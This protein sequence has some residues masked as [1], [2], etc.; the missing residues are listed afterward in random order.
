[1]I[2]IPWEFPSSA[3]CHSLADPGIA[4]LPVNPGSITG[5]PAGKYLNISRS[6][7]RRAHRNSN[8]T[9]KTVGPVKKS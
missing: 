1:M 8:K 2:R 4:K 6:A 9:N 3:I 5:F 7:G